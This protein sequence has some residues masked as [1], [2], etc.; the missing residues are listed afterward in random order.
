MDQGAPRPK[1][2][3]RTQYDLLL[4]TSEPRTIEEAASIAGCHPEYARIVLRR[5]ERK[6]YVERLD[7]MPSRW[8][9]RPSEPESDH[10]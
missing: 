8:R 3:S 9:M 10:V 2:L 4:A 7:P 5:L 1:G 6:G